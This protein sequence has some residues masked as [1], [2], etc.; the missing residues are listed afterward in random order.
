MTHPGIAFRDRLTSTHTVV[1]QS[2]PPLPPP[3]PTCGPEPFA[4]AF[5]GRPNLQID[6]DEIRRALGILFEPGQ[7]GEVRFFEGELSGDQRSGTA[8]CFFSEPEAMIAAL[9][10]D[11]VWAT[12]LHVTLNPLHPDVLCRRPVGFK[13]GAKDCAKDSEVLRRRW[14]LVDV[15]PTRVSGISA[16]DEQHDTAIQTAR[17]IRDYLSQRG[18]PTPVLA[19]SGNGAHLL[20][21]IEL[22]VAEGAVVEGVLQRLAESF[23]DDVVTVDRTVHNASRLTKLYGTMVR[24]GIEDQSRRHRQSRL[25]EVPDVLEIVEDR[26]LRELSSPQDARSRATRPSAA[27]PRDGKVNVEAWLEKHGIEHMPPKQEDDGRLVFTLPVCPWNDGHTD[28][29]AYVMQ[30]P[31]GGVH[32]G[33]HHNSCQGKGW[34]D[35]RDKYEPGWRDGNGKTKSTKTDIVDELI[36]IAQAWPLANSPDGSIWARMP[37]AGCGTAILTDDEKFRDR[38]ALEL[39]RATGKT[40][41]N[42]DLTDA[43]RIVKAEARPN[44]EMREVA[45]RLAEDG[46]Q[47]WLDLADDMGRAVRINADGWEVVDDPDACPVWFRRPTGMKPLPVPERGG[48]AEDLRRFVNIQDEATWTL[49]RAWLIGAFNPSGPYPLLA[50]RGEQGSAKSTMC[51]VVQGLVDPTV[52]GLR[53][54]PRSERD[55]MV[56]IHNARILAFDNVS[57]LAPWLQDALCRLATGAAMSTRKLYSDLDE[58]VVVA[59]RP[60]ILNGITEFVDR[61]DLLDRSLLLTLQPIPA[62][63]RRSEADLLREFEQARPRILGGLLDAVS[64]A[65]ANR[66]AVHLSSL[67]RMA[68]FARW[69]IAAEAGMG[70]AAG[71][72]M[73][74]YRASEQE[75]AEQILESHPTCGV[76]V[77]LVRGTPGGRRE[78]TAGELLEQIRRWCNANPRHTPADLPQTATG[79]GKYLARVGPVLRAAGVHMTEVRATDSSRTRLKQFSWVG[80]TGQ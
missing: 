56:G 58:T 26:L 53:S 34:M 3:M 64:A 29:S 67:P 13:M 46:R 23:D 8:S 6:E 35:L 36:S 31:D 24:K 61:S 32:A 60:I 40:A 41:N 69:A 30:F 73:A 16:T 21:R 1:S 38:L 18:W 75:A 43:I 25:L 65:M 28:R 17:R 78:C 80:T 51:R 15:D 77:E 76:I 66:E 20:Y 33:C 59:R 19:D 71:S 37:G 5:A 74:A 4:P 57:H 27:A 63:R 2:P 22:P 45:I 55:L 10:N 48:T 47:I 14:L 42:C 70:W 50:T 11:V 7:A 39:Y 54:C 52:G 79:L 72:F 49:L 9:R 12:S 68:D 62:G 44:A